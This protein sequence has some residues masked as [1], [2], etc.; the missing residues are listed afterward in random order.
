MKVIDATYRKEN[1]R[2]RVNLKFK[3]MD[4]LLDPDDPSPL[5]QKELT[6]EAEDAILSNAFAGKF[7]N[8]NNPGY[9]DTGCT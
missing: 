7:E 2:T 5:S 6:Q 1:G 8:A 4:Q 3:T 9:T